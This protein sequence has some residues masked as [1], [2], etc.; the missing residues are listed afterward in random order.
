MGRCAVC[1]KFIKGEGL[2]YD[3]QKENKNTVK[4]SIWAS[5]KCSVMDCIDEGFQPINGI[6]YC[7]R[8]YQKAYADDYAPKATQA[9]ISRFLIKMGSKSD[10]WEKIAKIKPQWATEAINYYRSGGSLET[11]SGE[12]VK[13]TLLKG[14]IK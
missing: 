14:G 8:H 10:I 5:K 1:D 13:S 4:K 9:Q 11:V 2:C 6:V 12:D 7:Y 3:C